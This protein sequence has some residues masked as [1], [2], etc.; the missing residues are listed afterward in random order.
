MGAQ[1]F[2][3]YQII[4]VCNTPRETTTVRFETTEKSLYSNEVTW[5]RRH[6]N[7]LVDA[8]IKVISSV[9]FS[10]VAQSCPTLCDPMNRS[11]PGLPVHHQLP[12][13]KGILTA[14]KEVIHSF[15][16]Y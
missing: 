1:K 4:R 14:I 11:T 12:E 5:L 16:K 3:V 15:P 13:Y 10:S 2:P 6:Q 8:L 7:D 9:L